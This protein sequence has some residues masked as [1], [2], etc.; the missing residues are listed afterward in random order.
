MILDRRK[1][2]LGCV[3]LVA[4]CYAAV[5]G[6]DA[7]A[8]EAP[9]H[10]QHLIETGNVKFEFYDPSKTR[11]EFPGHTA[12]NLHVRHRSSFK[13]SWTNGRGV[14]QLTIRIAVSGVSPRLKHTITLPDRLDSD[15]RWNDRLVRHEFDHVAITCD[16]RVLMLIAHLYDGV[17]RIER[18]VPAGERIDNRF[19]EKLVNERVAS[20]LHA[21][22]EAVKANQD[23]LD[24]V[25][26]HGRRRIADRKKFFGALYTEPNLKKIGFSYLGDSR[27]ILKS[28]AY[29]KAELP[30]HVD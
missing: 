24:E 11:R 3:V 4:L 9:P 13:Y 30:Y 10:F 29:L 18:E 22:V 8:A 12:F 28:E 6:G 7:T 16:P 21:V 17:T 19:V 20:R 14:R 26:H 2:R 27:D 25:T 5:N 23:L 15:R 1:L